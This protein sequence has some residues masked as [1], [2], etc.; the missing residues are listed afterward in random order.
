LS[1]L[2]PFAARRFDLVINELLFNPR[3]YGYDFV[4][5]YNRSERVISLDNLLISNYEN[6][7]IS[8]SISIASRGK[9]LFPG[10]FY[11]ITENIQNILS[12]YPKA[13]NSALYQV[14]K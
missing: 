6:G 8:N 13:Y 11:A 14:Q 4:E 9:V 3:A 10:E 7:Q 1:L 2:L 5:L 12:E